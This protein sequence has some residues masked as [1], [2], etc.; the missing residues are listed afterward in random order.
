MTETEL[1]ARFNRQLP[2]LLP[3][4]DWDDVLRRAGHIQQAHQRRGDAKPWRRG[5]RSRWP[6]AGTDRDGGGGGSPD[7]C[8]RRA[9]LS[10]L[11]RAGIARIP[12]LSQQACKRPYPV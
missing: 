2:D 6:A 10:V 4:P 7:A 3:A 1:Q 5:W 12:A 11:Q 8:G 9:R